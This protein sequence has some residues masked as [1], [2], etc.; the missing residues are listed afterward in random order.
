MHHPIW[1][2]VAWTTYTAGKLCMMDINKKKG[3]S[4]KSYLLPKH[5]SSCGHAMM[6]HHFKL[7]RGGKT[8]LNINQTA[9]GGLS[10]VYRSD[11]VP[12]PERLCHRTFSVPPQ[13]DRCDEARCISGFGWSTNR[14]AQQSMGNSSPLNA[15]E[16]LLYF[17]DIYL[18]GA[19]L[20]TPTAASAPPPPRQYMEQISQLRRQT[21]KPGD[22]RWCT[23]NGGWR[24]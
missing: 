12:Q 17:S 14:S 2:G 1:P 3:S 21:A 10:G 5:T 6:E 18:K 20:T 8:H 16:R 4:I 24:A 13:R 19:L 15:Q 11:R 23:R 7:Q 22:V 9:S